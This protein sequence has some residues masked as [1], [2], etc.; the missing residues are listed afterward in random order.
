MSDAGLALVRARNDM[1][2]AVLRA[3][4]TQDSDAQIEAWRAV[5]KAAADLARVRRRYDKWE[6]DLLR[7]ALLV[8]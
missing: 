7:R 2:N 3:L 6:R 4:M 5:D 1:R 8:S